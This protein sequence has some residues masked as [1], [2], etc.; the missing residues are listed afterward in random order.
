MLLVGV[1]CY[2]HIGCYILIKYLLLISH[3]R[4]VLHSSI[5]NGINMQIEKTPIY[6]LEAGIAK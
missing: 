6:E 5:N 1:R 3:F 4:K 2:D